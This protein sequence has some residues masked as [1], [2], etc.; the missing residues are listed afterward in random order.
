MAPPESIGVIFPAFASFV[1][2]RIQEGP[3]SIE[4]RKPLWSTIV[5]PRK[6]V[7]RFGAPQ[8]LISIGS[9]MT[10]PFMALYFSERF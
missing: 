1:Y 2:L 8:L 9:G 10:I 5:Q 6:L 3:R 4:Q 7:G